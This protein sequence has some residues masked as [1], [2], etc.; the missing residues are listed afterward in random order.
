M[1]PKRIADRFTQ[2]CRQYESSHDILGFEFERDK[3]SCVCT[4]FYRSVKIQLVYRMKTSAANSPSTLYCRV[5]PLKNCP[6]FMHLPHIIPLLG[7]KDYRA[8]YYPFIET[9]ERME[10]CFNHLVAFL[11]E[12]LPAMESFAREERAIDELKEFISNNVKDIDPES[13]LCN[14]SFEQRSYIFSQRTL[15]RLWVVAFTES[16]PWKDYLFGHT[17]KALQGYGK[18]EDPIPY[19]DGLCEF[20]KTEEGRHFV[21][22]PRECFSQF[23]MQAA[24]SGREDG[25]TLF[26]CMFAFYPVCAA[27][28]CV[29]MGTMQLISSFGTLCWFGDPWYLGALLGGIPAIFG[30]IALR[31]RIIPF[32][33]RKRSVSQLEY[34]D[35][36][37]SDT[38]NGVARIIFILVAGVSLVFCL[39]TGRQN[40]RFFDG[41]LDRN[42]GILGHEEYRYDEITA[43]Y[44]M[45]SRYVDDG[46]RID[47]PSYV[48]LFEDGTTMDLYSRVE[49]HEAEEYV[50]PILEDLDIP[51]IHI[52]SNLEL[53]VG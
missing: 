46:R 43:I 7:I 48:L 26:K 32:I 10:S 8:C 50:L 53:P 4:L 37:N 11:D 17:A 22:M 20:L 33:N 47:R 52:D 15:D 40:I 9:D 2:L 41:Y 1:K 21:P 49:M 19:I 12:L 28:F 18:Y 38:I 36:L 3:K 29:L 45:D 34:D 42:Y 5:F 39:Y 14:D 35:I 13:V 24:T 30:G 31:R 25:L 51:V 23:D 16:E 27:F 44:K 6:V